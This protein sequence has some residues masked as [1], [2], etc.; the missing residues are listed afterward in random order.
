MKLGYHLETIFCNMCR[1][2]K[3]NYFEIDR[4]QEDWYMQGSWSQEEE[5]KFL[6]WMADYIHKMPAAQREMYGTSYMRKHSCTQ[7]AQLFV[8]NYGWK[9]KK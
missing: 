7:A 4:T 9:T 3:V 8:L 1:I 6:A 5:N 2:A